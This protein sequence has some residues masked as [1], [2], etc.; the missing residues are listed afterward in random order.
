MVKYSG[1]FF[2]TAMFIVFADRLAYSV[3]EKKNQPLA[4]KVH[5]LQPSG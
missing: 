1:K 3:E 5:N 4:S 2:Q